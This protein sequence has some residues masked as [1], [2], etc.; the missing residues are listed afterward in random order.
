M[1]ATIQAKC[2]KTNNTERPSVQTEKGGKTKPI[3]NVEPRG[4]GNSPKKDS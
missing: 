2:R 1:F 4:K 3:E